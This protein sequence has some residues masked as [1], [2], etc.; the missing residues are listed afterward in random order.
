MWV[1][2]K[3]TVHTHRDQ[4][5]NMFSKILPHCPPKL[6]L[7]PV[8]C[9][10][11]PSSNGLVS[12]VDKYFTSDTNSQ[13]TKASLSTSGT[14]TEVALLSIRH[15]TVFLQIL[16]IECKN[17]DF[18]FIHKKKKNRALC[19]ILS[20]ETMSIPH[21]VGLPWLCFLMVT[22]LLT[23]LSISVCPLNQV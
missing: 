11:G 20:I 19:K 7:Y 5:L 17:S 3:A 4:G 9:F 8:M 2:S 23:K 16:R 22:G 6:N 15:L 18:Y 10:S 13:K 12:I 1:R 21:L 14:Y